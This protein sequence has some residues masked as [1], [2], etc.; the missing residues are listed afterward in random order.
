MLNKLN[1]VKPWDAVS[2]RPKRRVCTR[3]VHSPTSVVTEFHCTITP[4]IITWCRGRRKAGA[5]D[6]ETTKK[7]KDTVLTNTYV[8][9]YRCVEHAV[10][11]FPALVSLPPF[12][13]ASTDSSPRIEEKRRRC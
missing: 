5:F 7:T 1:E 10:E 6:G 3:K 9:T 4:A 13:G 2:E 11:I 8:R 12:V